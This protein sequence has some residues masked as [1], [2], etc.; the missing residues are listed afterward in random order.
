MLLITSPGVQPYQ[1]Q[2]KQKTLCQIC[3]MPR[4]NNSDTM[5]M[6]ISEKPLQKGIHPWNV[7]EGLLPYQPPSL[8]IHPLFTAHLFTLFI[9]DQRCSMRPGRDQ[10][11]QWGHLYPLFLS[12]N[13]AICQG[14]TRKP[15]FLE[16]RKGYQWQSYHHCLCPSVWRS[17]LFVSQEW[18][19]PLA[20]SLLMKPFCKLPEYKKSI[21]KKE[22]QEKHNPNDK[23]RNREKEFKPVAT[24]KDSWPWQAAAGLYKPKW[25]GISDYS[26][27]IFLSCIHSWLKTSVVSLTESQSRLMYEQDWAKIQET[28]V[29]NPLSCSQAKPSPLCLALTLHPVTCVRVGATW[30]M[31]NINI[32]Q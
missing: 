3:A 11:H 14:W 27:F 21:L 30:I 16:L 2:W 22:I 28:K 10:R 15:L 1:E 9:M 7:R 31:V 5:D 26:F 4:E 24:K 19:H 18:I 13:S 20:F 12:P 17:C 25:M 6:G 8:R 29:C 32:Q 23:S